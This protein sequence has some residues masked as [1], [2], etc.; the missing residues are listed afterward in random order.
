MNAVFTTTV[1]YIA[2]TLAVYLNGQLKRQDLDDGWLE[3]SPG[4]GVFTMKEVPLAG[5]VV[6]CFYLALPA[7]GSLIVQELVCPLVG[8]ISPDPRLIGVLRVC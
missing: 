3:T 1:P 6:Q 2:G 4:T 7:S 8:R 5:D